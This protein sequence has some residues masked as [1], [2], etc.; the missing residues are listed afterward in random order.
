MKRMF[1]GLLALAALSALVLVATTSKRVVRPVYAQSGCSIST[2]TGNYAFSQPG[3]EAKSHLKGNPLPFAVVGVSTFD[4]AG[5][6]SAAYTDMSPGQPTYIPVQGNGS[7]TYTVNSDCTGSISITRG[8]A[9]GITL[10]LVIMDDGTE[11][12]GIN[13]TP[14]IIA[15]ADFKKQ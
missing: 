5:N 2:L 1:S 7:G 12:F 4:G 11:V 9:A 8:D 6:F 13:T 15:T 14:F 10:N 3:F